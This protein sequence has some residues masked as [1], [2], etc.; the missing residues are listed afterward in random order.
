VSTL[1][2]GYDGDLD[3]FPNNECEFVAWIAQNVGNSESYNPGKAHDPA[4][5]FVLFVIGSSPTP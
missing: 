5:P 2:A 4:P 3:P 1:S